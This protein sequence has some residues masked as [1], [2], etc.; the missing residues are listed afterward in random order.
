MTQLLES[1]AIVGLILFFVIYTIVF[2]FFDLSK[3]NSFLEYLASLY[4][5][6]VVISLVGFVLDRMSESYQQQLNIN[7]QEES[8][9]VDINNLFLKYYPES[10]ELYRQINYNDKNITKSP[11]PTNVNPTKKVMIDS[12]ICLTIIQR[13]EN[14]YL[15]MI[16]DPNYAQTDTYRGWVKV[17]RQWFHSPIL[18]NIWNKNKNI[19]FSDQITNFIDQVIIGKQDTNKLVKSHALNIPTTHYLPTDFFSDI[20]IQRDK[21]I[22]H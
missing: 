10:F 9:F 5:L 16:Q 6:I 12:I 22:T 19:L 8:G 11:I 14:I 15:I 7:S 4:H 3:Y 18:L 21:S 13:I 20:F 2:W 17:W 1:P